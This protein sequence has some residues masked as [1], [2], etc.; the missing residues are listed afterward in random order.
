MRRTRSTLGVGLRLHVQTRRQSII[1]VE[2]PPGDP[3]ENNS[4]YMQTPARDIAISN[5]QSYPPR[6]LTLAP[7]IAASV[8][9]VDR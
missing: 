9:V 3:T 2:T 8:F 5:L 6:T 7:V 1:Y 4:D